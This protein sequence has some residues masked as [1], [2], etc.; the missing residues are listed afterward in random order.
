MCF[1]VEDILSNRDLR[2][3]LFHSNINI[4]LERYYLKSKSICNADRSGHNYP[5]SI[6]QD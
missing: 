5:E 2:V 4:I 3:V 6:H 1:A